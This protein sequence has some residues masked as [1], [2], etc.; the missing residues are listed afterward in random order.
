MVKARNRCG[1]PAELPP[2]EIVARVVALNHKLAEEERNG[3]IRWLRPE[4][5]IPRF[6]PDK[7]Q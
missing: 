3:T 6:A 5:Q 2:A 1:W 4:Y 7:A